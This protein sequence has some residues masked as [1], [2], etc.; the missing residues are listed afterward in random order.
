MY[1]VVMDDV[2]ENYESLF[3]FLKSNTQNQS[4]E[5]H[6]NKVRACLAEFH[7]AGFVHGDFR[8][9]NVMVRTLN[10]GGLKDGS[11]RIVD[12]DS[13][14]RIEK[15]RYP[16]IL[17]THDTWRPPGATGGASIEAG[18]DMAMLDHIWE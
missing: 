10:R 9:T 11:F 18:H 3:N 12:F 8:D 2:S 6:M 17:N 7:Q 13:C 14:G 15:A 1:M 4:A 16:F 5:E